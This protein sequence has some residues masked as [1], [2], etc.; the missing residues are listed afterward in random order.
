MLGHA[1]GIRRERCCERRIHDSGITVC[2]TLAAFDWHFQPSLDRSVVEELA[3]LG[4]LARKQDLVITGKPGTGKSHILGAIALRACIAGR[5]VRYARFLDIPPV[6]VRSTAL[7]TGAGERPRT[8]RVRSL[9]RLRGLL[10][11]RNGPGGLPRAQLP[12]RGGYRSLR[13][14]GDTGR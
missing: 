3:G 9:R 7:G 4:F 14:A 5:L 12:I 10:G 8:R 2:H 13:A 11:V 1:A 6:G